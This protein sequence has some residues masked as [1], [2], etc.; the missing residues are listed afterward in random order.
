MKNMMSAG[1]GSGVTKIETIGPKQESANYGPWTK[2]GPQP[3]FTNT[4]L[5]DQSHHHSFAYCLWPE[6]ARIFTII[7]S[8]KNIF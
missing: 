5:L 3:V 2:S 8:C 4:F 6:K 7:A 1:S